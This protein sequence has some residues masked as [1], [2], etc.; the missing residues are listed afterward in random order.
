MHF[1]AVAYRSIGVA[2]DL[3][4]LVALSDNNCFYTIQL[5]HF[6]KNNPHAAIPP[7]SAIAFNFKSGKLVTSKSAAS[8]ADVILQKYAQD[9]ANL[10]AVAAICKDTRD[11]AMRRRE[12]L[13]WFENDFTMAHPSSSHP[14]AALDNLSPA[15]TVQSPLKLPGFSTLPSVVSADPMHYM[16]LQTAGNASAARRTYSL[17]LNG[18]NSKA[19]RQ[20]VPGAQTD[21]ILQQ[22]QDPT[23]QFSPNVLVRSIFDRAISVPFGMNV[24]D[25]FVV[26]PTKLVALVR[27]ES[28]STTGLFALYDRATVRFPTQHVQ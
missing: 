15:W 13:R 3:G 28:S 5:D 14:S 27:K 22:S 16:Y 20:E 2:A 18:F 11:E 19:M 10:Q 25:M 7:S 9:S 8:S 24:V 17:T 1:I 4:Q 23:A 26:G 21:P 6:F 12:L